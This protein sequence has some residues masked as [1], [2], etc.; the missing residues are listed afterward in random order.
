MQHSILARCGRTRLRPA[1]VS[2]PLLLLLGSIATAQ[3]P[4][5]RSPGMSSYSGGELGQTD[6]FSND[7]NPALGFVIDG[8]VDWRAPDEGEN[9][10][11]MSLRVME[12]NA[13]AW[14]D[15]NAWAYV[16]VVADDA[17]NIGLEEAAVVY[18][19][20]EGNSTLRAGRFFVDF[21][22]QMQTHL[23]ELRTLERPLVLREF[24]GAELAG[25]GV[26]YDNWF[27]VGDSPVRFS[28]GAFASLLE[29]HDHGDDGHDHDAHAEV[30]SAVPDRKDFD[31]FSLSA[32][33]TGLRDVGEN[34]ILQLG[35]SAR[36]VPEFELVSEFVDED[37]GEEVHLHEA[38]LANT[39][40]G[41][42]ASYGWQ[43]DTGNR[44]VLCGGEL[45][46]F[47]GDVAAHVHHGAGEEPELEIQDDAV[48]GW[49][50]FAD[51][52][53]NPYD[54]AG[55]QFST[56]ETPEDPDAE[57]SELDLYWTHHFT[58]LRRL[59]LGVTLIDDEEHGDD[60]RAYLQFTNIFGTHTHGINW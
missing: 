37:S 8:W 6:R 59:R 53:W 48:T 36:H 57:V 42:D 10:G 3:G 51:Y 26:Q 2:S 17:E 12:A 32:R 16:V 54:S 24:L 44:N 38:G 41:L 4:A 49:Y 50:A 35:L 27:A 21:G 52:G 9:G 45:L 55:L 28:V 14:V 1:L 15:P 40:F 25:T 22:K 29:G 58:H 13:S 39:V 18:T 33:L 46:A 7:F 60:A 19:G 47:T 34:G 56:I 5:F 43:D 11:D 20:F 30:E 23:E 31:E